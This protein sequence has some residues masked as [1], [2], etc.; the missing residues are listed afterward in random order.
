M[1]FIFSNAIA[2]SAICA[3]NMTAIMASFNGPYKYQENSGSA[4]E[5]KHVPYLNRQQCDQPSS[6]APHQILDN[7]RYQLMDDAVQSTTLM[8]LY[9][10]TLERYV[11]SKVQ[12]NL[13][14]RFQ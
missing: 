10:V 5:R 13:S 12:M 4:W 9:T 7:Q 6:N 14:Q 8:P 11:L 1:Y 2:G 3:F